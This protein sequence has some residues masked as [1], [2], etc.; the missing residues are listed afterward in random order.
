MGKT[1]DSFDALGGFKVNGTTVINSSGKIVESA[2]IEITDGDEFLDNNGN[3]ALTWGVVA[4]AV[5]SLSI[6]NAETTVAPVLGVSGTDTNIDLRFSPK[7]AGIG[8]VYSE[9][10]GSTGA[11][12][13]LFQESASVVSGDSPGILRLSGVSDVDNKVVYGDLSATI[14][15]AT[16]A[17]ESS[18][19]LLRAMNGGTLSS[20]I[21]G[22]FIASEPIINV[23]DGANA[24]TIASSGEFDLVLTTGHA[25]TGS[26][27]IS[28]GA[29]ILEGAEIHSG[30]TSSSGAAAVPITGRIHEIITTGTGDALTLVDGEEGQRITLLYV[31][32]TA[33]ADTAILTP[34]TLAGGS[35]ITFND[36]GDSAELVYSSTGGWYVVGLGGAAAVA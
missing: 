15:D 17:S 16:D 26:I 25:T 14:L 32:E 29:V 11:V 22:E 33:P 30:I 3:A 6:T 12:L 34:T 24:P 19:V 7:G 21:S 18:A 10:A 28:D 31:D 2:G 13:E 8:Q 4:S 20:I 23:G 35:T 5:N 1:N 27:T 36:L 9:E